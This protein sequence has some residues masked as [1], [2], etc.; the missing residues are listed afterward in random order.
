VLFNEDDD[1]NS[2]KDCTS[3]YIQGMSPTM[4]I[5]EG[6]AK[7]YYKGPSNKENPSS[8]LEILR[9]KEISRKEDQQLLKQQI[10]WI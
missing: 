5:R 3:F 4:N 6:S 10:N 1:P 2:I 9:E 7:S 8:R